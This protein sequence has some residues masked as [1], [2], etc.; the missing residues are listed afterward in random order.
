MSTGRWTSLRF[1]FTIAIVPIVLLYFLNWMSVPES[2]SQDW[3][4][5]HSLAARSL[6]DINREHPRLYFTSEQLSLL[7]KRAQP[8]LQ[9]FR[10]FG[11][12]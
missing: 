6:E 1:G 7:R 2:F 4:Q 9:G 11:G 3:V 12:V 10:D 8:T 5:E